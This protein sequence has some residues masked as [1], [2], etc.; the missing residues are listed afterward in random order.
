VTQLLV[1]NVVIAPNKAL[2]LPTQCTT[3][4]ISFAQRKGCSTEMPTKIAMQLAC[5]GV[6][7]ENSST[8]LST[9]GF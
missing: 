5:F 3:I 8:P 6:M 7:E 2:Y 4:N 9:Q 1:Q